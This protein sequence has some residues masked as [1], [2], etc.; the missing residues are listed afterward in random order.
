M[1]PAPASRPERPAGRGALS[2]AIRILAAPSL[3]TLGLSAMAL[4]R[5]RQNLRP[6]AS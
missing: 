6:P 4:Q 5:L 2:Q 1:A 3:I